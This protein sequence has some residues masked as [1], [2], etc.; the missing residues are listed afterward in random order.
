MR[1][2]GSRMVAAVAGVAVALMTAG[3]APGSPDRPAAARAANVENP[4]LSPT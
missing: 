4:T 1:L 3:V 2:S